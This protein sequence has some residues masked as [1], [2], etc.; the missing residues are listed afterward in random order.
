[1]ILMKLVLYHVH[2]QKC[3]KLKQ[4]HWNAFGTKTENIKKFWY[5]FSIFS[6][7]PDGHYDLFKL[8]NSLVN[9][10]EI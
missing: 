7:N 9:C 2:I 8:I 10:E 3:P 5:D 4:I 6:S 1:M